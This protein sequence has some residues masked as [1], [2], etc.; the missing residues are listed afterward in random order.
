MVLIAL[1]YIGK[2]GI[3]IQVISKITSVLSSE[4]LNKLRACKMPEWMRSTLILPAK[5]TECLSPTSTYPQLN[6]ANC[7]YAVS[8]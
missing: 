5:E 3:S 4:E 6:K 8:R 2:E 1:H 7:R